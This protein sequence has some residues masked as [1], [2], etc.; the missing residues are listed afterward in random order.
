MQDGAAPK[1]VTTGEG[2]DADIQMMRLRCCGGV[3]GV[4]WPSSAYPRRL[5]NTI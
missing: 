5:F 1:R 3:A 4:V 2:L